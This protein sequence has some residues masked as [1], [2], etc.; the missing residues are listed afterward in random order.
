MI[1][2]IFKVQVGWLYVDHNNQ[3]NS[4]LNFKCNNH[5]SYF[6]ISWRRM[7]RDVLFTNTTRDWLVNEAS[8][9]APRDELLLSYLCAS[10]HTRLRISSL[11]PQQQHSWQ[12]ATA[13]T[14]TLYRKSRHSALCLLYFWRR[15]R[16]QH[17]LAP[18]TKIVVQWSLKCIK[19]K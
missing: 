18:T 15:H 16:Y 14:I 11:D 19:I 3:Y 12:W 2:T 9:T 8:A 17:P 5:N 13:S 1:L 4:V 10:N 7:W 6:L